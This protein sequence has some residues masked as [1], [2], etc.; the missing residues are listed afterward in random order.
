MEFVD[1]G[2]CGRMMVDECG[3]FLVPCDGNHLG[4]C[5]DTPREQWKPLY[6]PTVPKALL[7][8]CQVRLAAA[9]EVCRLAHE[10]TYLPVGDEFND[11]RLRHILKMCK[12]VAMWQKLSGYAK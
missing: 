5:P 11:E 10:L 3:E 8:V 4:A 9:E 6:P 7:D 2:F 12:K 1:R